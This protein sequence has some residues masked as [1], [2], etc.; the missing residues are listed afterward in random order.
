MLR[1]L[2]NLEHQ[3]GSIAHIIVASVDPV[4]GA[5]GIQ[6]YVS[7]LLVFSPYQ[8]LA[9]SYCQG[10][11]DVGELNFEAHYG[12]DWEENVVQKFGDWASRI[13]GGKPKF[14]LTTL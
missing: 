10:K 1:V 8:P 4:S 11:T 6:K 7:S 2:K 12:R 13:F 5:M 9:R 3:T 14:H